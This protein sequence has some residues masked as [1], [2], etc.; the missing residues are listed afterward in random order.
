VT[1]AKV[2]MP[3]GDVGELM[4]K[5]PIVMMGYYGNEEA[6]QET[7]EPDGGLHTG[8]LATMDVVGHVFIVD[9]K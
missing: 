3:P 8:D 1:D 4:I 2:T 6:T 7:I 5:G 9:R